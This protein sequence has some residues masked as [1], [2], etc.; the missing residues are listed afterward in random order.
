VVVLIEDTDI[1]KGV[2]VIGFDMLLNQDEDG[3]PFCIRFLKC[4]H[5]LLI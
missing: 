3:N 5:Y 2:N 4:Y 1:T